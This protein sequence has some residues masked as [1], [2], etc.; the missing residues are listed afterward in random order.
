MAKKLSREVQG[1]QVLRELRERQLGIFANFEI[2]ISPWMTVVEE[3]TVISEKMVRTREDGVKRQGRSLSTSSWLLLR[4]NRETLLDSDKQW[5]VLRF[6]VLG[7]GWNSGQE[8]DRRH[9]D[10]ATSTRA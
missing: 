6:G 10:Q 8:Q 5:K 2:W 1:P 4:V 3:T 7:S 9:P